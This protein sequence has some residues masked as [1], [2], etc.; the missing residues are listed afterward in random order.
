MVWSKKQK[1]K[2]T[3]GPQ[4]ISKTYLFPDIWISKLQQSFY[5]WCKITSHLC[6][7]NI[8]QSTKS[9]SNN[10]LV[11]VIQISEQKLRS[12]Q[13][14]FWSTIHCVWDSNL[15]LTRLLSKSRDRKQHEMGNDRKNRAGLSKWKSSKNWILFQRVCDQHQ[16]FLSF[17]EKQ[18]EAK[19][20]Y[21]LLWK[22]SRC[23]QFQALHLTKMCWVTQH[24]DEHELSQ[25][26][27]P[28]VLIIFIYGSTNSSTLFPYNTAFLCCSFAST[29]C[30]NHVPATEQ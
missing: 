18:H 24:V 7:T 23:Y 28:V 2:K 8:S 5:F 21:S 29:Y 3:T 16:N 22:T 25:V 4:Y 10:I 15:F 30:P 1:T 14:N 17:I 20:P 26:T 27:V 19:I 11:W 12:V 13:G 6:W 9:K